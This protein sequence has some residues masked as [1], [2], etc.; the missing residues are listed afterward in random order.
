M[1]P[2]VAGKDDFECRD[3]F[4]VIACFGSFGLTDARKNQWFD[5][6]T[7][8]HKFQA[9]SGD[10]R[11]Q[12]STYGEKTI[13]ISSWTIINGII[14]NNGPSVFQVKEQIDSISNED[15]SKT[16]KVLTESLIEETKPVVTGDKWG[17]ISKSKKKLLIGFFSGNF[18]LSGFWFNKKKSTI[19]CL[20]THQQ[21]LLR[22][23]GSWWTNWNL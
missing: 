6:S 13:S 20:S 5:S 8:L 22:A 14:W 9:F 17:W 15:V 3:K 2:A 10:E 21:V 4:E 11:Y 18:A 1:K 16:K 12:A 7:D 19:F 23:R